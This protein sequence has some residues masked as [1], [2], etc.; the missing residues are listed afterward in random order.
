MVSLLAA[1][2]HTK[3][4][5]DNPAEAA[6]AKNLATAKKFIEAFSAKGSITMASLVTD[7]FM[8]SPPPVGADSLPKAK[9]YVAMKNFMGTYNDITFTNVLWRKGVDSSNQFDGGV[10]VY[11]LWKSTFASSGKTGLLKYYAFMEFNSD[12]KMTSQSEFFNTPDL[13]IEH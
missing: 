13:T 11:G 1:C 3:P 5:A 10:R 7:D 6:Y 9:W 8:W 12:G 2:T 4:T